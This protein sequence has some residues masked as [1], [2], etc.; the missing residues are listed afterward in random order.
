MGAKRS[1]GH[2]IMAT[3]EPA[4]CKSGFALFIFGLL[5]GATI[6]RFKHAR[7]GL[8]AHLTAVQ[9]GTALMAM[10][11]IWPT[12]CNDPT[13]SALLGHVIW[14]S[15]WSLAVGLTLAAM[16]GA[17]KVLPIAGTGAR[18]SPYQERLVATL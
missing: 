3:V 17:G 14:A 11:A 15:M 8:S 12:L 18:A 1:D 5:L 9:G 7:I 4:L 2:R 13:A 16:F 10:G 6:P